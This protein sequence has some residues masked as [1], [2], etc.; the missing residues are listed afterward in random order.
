MRLPV[1]VEPRHTQTHTG[2][3]NSR[4]SPNQPLETLTSR[5]ITL[6]LAG[7]TTRR[8]VPDLDGRELGHHVRFAGHG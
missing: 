1:A 5:H 4:Q 3:H 8:Y 2:N 7:I 6:R